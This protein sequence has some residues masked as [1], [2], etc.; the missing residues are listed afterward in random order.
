MWGSRYY[1]LVS[2]PVTCTPALLPAL[3]LSVTAS[4]S[5]G[6]VTGTPSLAA[7]G[8]VAGGSGGGWDVDSTPLTGPSV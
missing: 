5:W 7:K 6:H 4:Q 3:P 8:V 1:A 2:S